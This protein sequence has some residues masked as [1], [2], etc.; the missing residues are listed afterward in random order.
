[1][2]LASDVEE[3]F[4]T[5]TFPAT[6]AEL[7]EAYGDIEL[8]LADGAVTL[9]EVLEG[10]A[11]EEFETAEDAWLTTCGALSEDAIGRKGYSDR[12]PCCPGEDG[13]EQLSF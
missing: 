6:N 9:G 12:D 5:H 8:E 2:R 1:M 13:H 3:T 4:E 10:C 11:D 7:V